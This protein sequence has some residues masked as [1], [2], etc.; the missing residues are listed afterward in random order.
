ME[1]LENS[2]FVARRLKLLGSLRLFQSSFVGC[3]N[4]ITQFLVAHNG[5]KFDF[6]VL[7]KAAESCDLFKDLE[8]SVVAFVDSLAVLREK[9]PRLHSHSQENLAKYLRLGKYKCT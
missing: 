6:K 1:W 3:N 8:K 2:L 5:K 4:L 9:F 7:S